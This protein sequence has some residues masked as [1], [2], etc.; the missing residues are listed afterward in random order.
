MGIPD[1]SI[2]VDRARDCRWAVQLLS[3]N[4]TWDR[5]SSPKL[6]CCAATPNTDYYILCSKLYLTA[7]IMLIFMQE[8]IVGPPHPLRNGFHRRNI[9]TLSVQELFFQLIGLLGVRLDVSPVGMV[10][11]FVHGASLPV[12]TWPLATTKRHFLKKKK[13]CK[14]FSCNLLCQNCFVL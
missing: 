13:C 9:G 3:N 5:V 10:E 6:K 2:F 8:K 4:I 14:I 7:V 1:L 12:T 11:L